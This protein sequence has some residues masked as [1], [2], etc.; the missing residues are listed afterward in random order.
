MNESVCI[1][2]SGQEFVL[3]DIPKVGTAIEIPEFGIVIEC[4]P[5][6]SVGPKGKG[7]SIEKGTGRPDDKPKPPQSG[8]GKKRGRPKKVRPEEQPQGTPQEEEPFD[9]EID[10]DEPEIQEEDVEPVPTFPGGEPFDP[11]VPAPP[12]APDASDPATRTP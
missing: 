1:V 8:T 7:R 10:F 4:Q 9:G 11:D 2:R 5:V 12:T 6:L 3:I